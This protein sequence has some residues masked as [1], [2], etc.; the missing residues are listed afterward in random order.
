MVQIKPELIYFLLPL[1]GLSRQIAG[2]WWKAM[3]RFIMPLI[4]GLTL[5]LFMGWS[6]WLLPT[7]AAFIGV[8]TL[9]VTLIGDSVKTPL[10]RVWVCLLGF[11]QALPALLMF[12]DEWKVYLLLCLVPMVVYGLLINLSNVETTARLFRWKLVEFTT[13]S[14]CVYPLCVMLGG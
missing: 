12:L 9:P 1:A 10:N 6:W 7:V 5:F 4:I 8:K 14:F 2:T 11:I 13:G 3:D